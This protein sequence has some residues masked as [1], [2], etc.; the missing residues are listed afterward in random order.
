MQFKSLCYARRQTLHAHLNI[1]H[2][3]CLENYLSEFDQKQNENL[4][5]FSPTPNGVD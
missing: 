1:S 3:L 2:R 4:V 5:L